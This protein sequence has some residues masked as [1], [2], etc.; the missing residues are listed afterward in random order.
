VAKGTGWGSQDDEAIRLY[1][2]FKE[3]GLGQDEEEFADVPLAQEL[4][5]K[6]G[7]GG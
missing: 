3:R 7:V 6:G 2:M 5:S 1:K 4:A